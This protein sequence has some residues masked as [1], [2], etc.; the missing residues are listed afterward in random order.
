M[1]DP[2]DPWDHEVCNPIEDENYPYYSEYEI[3]THKLKTLYILKVF[4][5]SH[6]FGMI[7]QIS[8]LEDLIIPFSW[9]MSTCKD[10]YKNKYESGIKLK[11]DMKDKDAFYR[12]SVRMSKSSNKDCKGTIGIQTH[13]SLMKFFLNLSFRS[14]SMNP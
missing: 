3:M 9:L 12:K 2:W 6:L 1:H 14:M 5:W 11:A 10:W 13:I 4:I 7:F 8:H